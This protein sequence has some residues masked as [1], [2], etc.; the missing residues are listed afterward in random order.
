M[1]RHYRFMEN[2][3]T[4]GK[5][6]LAITIA[7]ATVLWAVGI[8][9]FAVPSA[10]AADM[11]S[12][13]KGESLSTLYYYGY[14]GS[15]YTFSNE[16]TYKTWY[17]DFDDVNEISDSDLADISLAGNVVYRPGDRW[18]KIQSDAKTYAVATDGT[19]HWVETED[20]ASGLAG[21]SWA[22]TIDDV[23]DV[24]FVDYS[25]G[26]SL[27]TASAFDGM[28][29]MDGSDY[30]IAWDG[31]KRMLTEDG[32]DANRLWDS[33]FLSGDSI[34]DS[35]LSAGDDID[36]EVSALTD[37][38][39]QGGTADTDTDTSSDAGG[40]TLSTSSS[41]P[42][43]ATL[44]TGANSVEVFS[45]DV[46]AGDDAATFDD[47]VLTL[48]S[49]AATTN[50]SNAYLY[51]GSTRLTDARSVNASTRQVTF[52][53]LG[54]SLDAGEARTL[55][56]RIE[57]S[58]SA[59]SGDEIAFEI[60]SAD[61][62]D[63]DGGD[64]SGS[65]PVSGN[66]FSIAS[67]S[68]GTVTIT[69]SGT[70]SDPTLGGND[71]TIGQFKI[72]A[73]NEAAEIE[74]I[75]LKIDSADDHSD[76]QLW[77]GSDM[78]G[79]GEY[80]GDKLVK[81]NLSEA[82]SISDGNSNVFTVSADIGGDATDN[83]KVYVD[84]AADVLAVGGDFGFGM[85]VDIAT[86]G[87]YD[88]AS[89]TA[90]TGNC[91]FSTIEGGEITMAWTGPGAGDITTNSQDNVL[92]EYTL[93]AAQAITVK[94]MDFIIAADDDGDNDAYD[95]G[96]SDDDSTAD[97]DGLVNNQSTAEANVSDIKI[98]NADTG[99][100]IMGP[101]DP[102]T[103]GNDGFQ[104]LTFSDDFT[105]AAG[106][107]LNLAVTADIDNNMTSGTEVS[108]VL[109]I[110]EF[111]AQ[112]S[113][114]DTIS[115][116]SIVP[117]GDI[118][119]KDQSAKSAS[120][121]IALGSTPGDVT[122]VMGM[123]DVGVANYSVNAGDAG[124][125][126]ISSITLSVYADADG[127]GTFTL[128][129]VTGVD[130][131]DYVESCS[132][133]DAAG[134]LLDGPD[135]PASNGQTILFDDVSWLI[136]AG[137]SEILAVECNFGNPG[138]SAGYV[139]FDINDMS[140]DI[141]AEDQDG[142][143]VDPTT[144]DPN[145]ATSPTD[146]VTIN[147]A[148]SLSVA[149]GADT[150]SA[151][152]I[153]TGSTNNLVAT[154]EIDATNEDFEITTITFSE[155]Q[156]EDDA[157]SSDSSAYANN[158]SLVTLEYPLED[159]TTTTDTTSMNGNEA[160]FSGINL[161]VTEEDEAHVSVYVDVPSTD[162]NSEGS[163]TSN[164][165]I[166]MGF[167]VDATNDDNFKAAGVGSGVT[168]DDDDVSAVGDDASGTDG[169]NTFVIRETQPT[170]TLSDDSPSG[171]GKVPSDQEVFRFNVAASSGEDVVLE[172]LVWKFSATD[173]GSGDWNQ[174]ASGELE[175]SDMDIYNLSKE[176]TSTA[177]DSDSDW[178]LLDTSANSCSSEDVGFIALALSTAET[179]P[180][181]ET[182]TYAVYLDSTGASSTNDDSMQ[183]ELSGDPLVTTYIGS[184]TLNETLSD[185]TDTTL[186]V[187]DSSGYTA[188]DI[189][190][191]DSDN[192]GD[193]DTGEERM[194]V[195]AVPD[196]TTLTV[197]RGYLNSATDATGVASDDLDRLPSAFVWQDDG[198][199]TVSTAAQERW[200]AYLVDDLPVTGGSLQF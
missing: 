79:S 58:S 11:G 46:A 130:V 82:F 9:A 67:S 115:T 16:K 177:L 109:D 42:S 148:G 85:T 152:F 167:F 105:M 28:T 122:T 196:G 154:Y 171:T 110:S 176:G 133:Y 69:K 135:S 22:S 26:S 200:G 179:I 199:T 30:Y 51:E 45:F 23:P 59:S 106:E 180:A 126:T 5:R 104:S 102:S 34:D 192:G 40:V 61:D 198:S 159:G 60:S 62:V 1:E 181:G 89:C 145:G 36:G 156:A 68:A 72:A 194:L 74:E 195:A 41:T 101:V 25:V 44:P 96:T 37:A 111:S 52:S 124:D 65:F 43:G 128:G 146:V 182:Y 87:T 189:I 121:V 151:D 116:A 49:V 12:L 137:D 99:A 144:D 4:I 7:A 8:A 131:N 188:G 197:V 76:Y 136:E 143:D 163:A 47:V 166:R 77:D 149:K 64:V 129:D 88:G 127:T 138:G 165:K 119:G 168:N 100:T 6:A 91:S 155:E 2:V 132:I 172:E 10:S 142:T 38:A 31:E 187:T 94:D 48:S 78:L 112:D 54:L 169:I 114:G 21:D 97:D 15:R 139:A 141:V 186:T 170:V 24:F 193:C 3:L 113:N 134:D 63:A 86:S 90:S 173:N 53:N 18:I 66:T 57:V 108:A 84:N 162:R 32:R 56:A 118:V 55:T 153:M 147:T 125:T 14:D 92:F 27:T 33:S 98:I 83:I 175:T 17:A 95:S 185:T 71:E 93:T 13:I 117:S 20:V 81:F 80:L 160:K 39:Q 183:L 29:Y 35:S 120:L 50:I 184:S 19:I 190:C 191:L 174:C 164:E 103:T 73:D 75:T 123:D 107:T 150:P 140:E 178:T 70:V 158:I 157:A 161:Y